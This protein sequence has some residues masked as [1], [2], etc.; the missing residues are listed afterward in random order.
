MGVSVPKNPGQL[1]DAR[2]VGLP[3]K[4]GPRRVQPAGQEIQRD[5]PRVFPKELGVVQRS[6]RMVV[7]DE[8]EGLAPVL[9]LDGGAHHAK[10]VAQMGSAR[11]FDPGKNARHGEKKDRR[12]ISG[13]A[14]VE[15]SFSP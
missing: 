15:S 7:G 3:E 8:I 9:P 6:Q 1:A 2:H 4:R 11:R 14:G 12:N 5:F 10:V 13:W